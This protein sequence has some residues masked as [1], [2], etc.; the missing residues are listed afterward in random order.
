MTS[1]DHTKFSIKIVVK[2]NG[3]I[4]VSDEDGRAFSRTY[5][6]EGIYDGLKIAK[7]GVFLESSDEYPVSVSLKGCTI[8]SGSMSEKIS[9]W[10]EAENE[11][12]M[13]SDLGG[14]NKAKVSTKLPNMT[15][16]RLGLTG[17]PVALC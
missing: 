2:W 10:Q 4:A 3:E 7:L 15:A 17:A 5:Q 16:V 8:Y 6:S 14:K 13:L 11:S 9:Y 12:G 1:I